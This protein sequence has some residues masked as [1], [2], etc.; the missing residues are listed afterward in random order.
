M[1]EVHVVVV[2]VVISLGLYFRV[3]VEDH[4]L[5]SSGAALGL[6]V[7][8]G[9]ELLLVVSVEVSIDGHVVYLSASRVVFSEFFVHVE[10]CVVS[11][12]RL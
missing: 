4:G 6:D 2:D 9:E 12:Y 7:S 5:L 11:S 1:R 10:V 8:L 3:V